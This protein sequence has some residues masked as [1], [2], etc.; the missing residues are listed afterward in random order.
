MFCLIDKGQ[1]GAISQYPTLNGVKQLSDTSVFRLVTDPQNQKLFTGCLENA[2]FS[3][4]M[5]KVIP[6]VKTW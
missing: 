2:D 1:T 5:M 3:I 6:G 4:H